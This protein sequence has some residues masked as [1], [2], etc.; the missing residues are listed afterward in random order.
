MPAHT[1]IEISRSAFLHNVAEF[2]RVCRP[3]A[4]M[5]V[6]KSNAYGHGLPETVQTLRGAVDWFAVNS[7]G[8]AMGVREYDPDTPVLVMGEASSSEYRALQE[9][10]AALIAEYAKFGDGLPA[11]AAE[12]RSVRPESPLIS[13][14]LS[15]LDA[16]RWLTETCPDLPF[17]L[18]VDTGMSRLGLGPLQLGPIFDYLRAHPECRWAGVMT[19]FANVEDVTDQSYARKQLEIFDTVRERAFRVAGEERP[20]LFHAAASAPALLLPEARLDLVRVGI[21]LYGLW[22]SSQ[23]R[24][25]ANSFYRE[26]GEDMPEL[27][28]VLRWLTR[29]VH[30]NPIPAGQDV[31]YGCTHRVQ[32]DTLVAVLPVGYFEGY[33]R[34]LS[35]RSHVLIRGRQARLLGRVCMNMIMVD[36]SH[37]PDVQVGDEAVLIGESRT[38]AV[39]RERISAEEL[40]EL[41]GTINYEVVTRIQ[42]DLERILV[43]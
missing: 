11:T 13:V 40:A 5:A 33:E 27:R 2:K 1:R 26:R 25:S 38:P 39:G 19:H 3:S 16:I 18:K 7:V 17:H 4:F 15:R 30:L 31:G 28:P 42:K 23:T 34:A 12:P 37:I 14:V 43:D 9:I 20:L 24:L 29:V 8:E 21:S 36:V 41:T 6:V 32:V 10:N 22:P 35:N